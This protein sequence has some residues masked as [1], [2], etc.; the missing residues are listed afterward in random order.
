MNRF[1]KNILFLFLI[2]NLC[3]NIFAQSNL[4]TDKYP[5]TYQGAIDDVINI[6]D[7]NQRILIRDSPK[8]SIGKYTYIIH[9]NKILDYRDIDFLK[10]C[11]QNIGV[12]YVHFEE[13][14]AV[15]LDGV[16]DKLNNDLELINFE[17]IEPEIYFSS[18]LAI[19]KKGKNNRLGYWASLPSWVYL[20]DYYYDQDYNNDNYKS[21]RRNK[22]LNIAKK[23]VLKK[24]K[25]SYLGL[26]YISLFEP[27]LEEK[28]KI[29]SSFYTNTN[30]YFTFPIYDYIYDKKL[31]TEKNEGIIG[32]E[33]NLKRNSSKEFSL[34]CFENIYHK[35]FKTANEY[36]S[37]LNYSNSNYLLKW[38]FL[39]T[40]STADYKI[41]LN[42]PIKLLEILIL[43]N[44]Y[45]YKDTGNNNLITGSNS[46]DDLIN[47]I[48]FKD[49]ISVK[50]PYHKRLMVC[51]D[52]DDSTSKSL[53]A[54]KLIADTLSTEELIQ[55]INPNSI[56]LYNK[57]YKTDD[58]LD[59]KY[60]VSFLIA[61]QY[62]RL[63]DYPDKD[64]IF[65]IFQ[66]YWINEHVS[67]PYQY[68]MTD[69]LIQINNENALK[70]FKEKFKVIPTEGSFTRQGILS[71]IIEYDFENNSNFIED[72][73]WKIQDT[74]F[75]Y[76]PKE[77]DL[78]LDLLR[79][80]DST[81]LDLYT[82][83]INDN[84]FKK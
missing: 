29:I 37:F 82:K 57:N 2:I 19:I 24:D 34:Q 10:S 55:I 27:N 4:E 79:E 16:W 31:D 70:L 75:N 54:L 39:K 69:L 7:E 58:L 41:L 71:S 83:I 23:I 56:E 33:Y 66:F 26:K 25:N 3:N 47:L 30:K 42:D 14:T 61:S 80:K 73:Y 32:I 60:L 15:I 38:K 36:E 9:K 62:E 53:N 59:Y 65:K 44:K 74:D 46:I 13:V 51:N 17:K 78:I 6:L 63:L 43:T 49:E 67:W 84:R 21:A 68:F 40:L 72:W 50:C 18:I 28:S 77:Q 52:N 48:E 5:K 35:T 81:T 11:A 20:S 12:E 22:L 1:K 45:Y 76:N 8:F 64:R